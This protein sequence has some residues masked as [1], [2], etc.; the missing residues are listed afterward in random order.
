MA[1]M[2]IAKKGIRALGIAESFS[3]RERSIIGGV[4]M[5]KDLRIDGFTFASVS[6]GGMD[7][8]EEIIRMIAR[9]ERDDLNVVMLSGCI[10][11]WFNVIDPAE[12]YENIEVPVICVTYED[13]EGLEDDIM[14]HFP[15]DEV[16]LSLYR[17]LIPKHRAPSHR[18]RDL[19]QGMGNGLWRGGEDL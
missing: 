15:G 18:Q 5:R 10:I 4:V 19:N 6:V 2:H 9:L 3:G 11:S 1:S 7:A 8:T 12:I 16:R 14:H 13:S 17:K